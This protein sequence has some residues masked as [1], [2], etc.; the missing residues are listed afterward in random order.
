MRTDRGARRAADALAAISSWDSVEEHDLCLIL[1]GL[2]C[3]ASGEAAPA[4]LG[5]SKPIDHER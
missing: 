5:R 3:P 4:N 2:H 1:Q